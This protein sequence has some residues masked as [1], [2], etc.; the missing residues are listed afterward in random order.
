MLV[1]YDAAFWQNGEKL[2]RNPAE[3]KLLKERLDKL[4][5]LVN[6]QD[7]LRRKRELIK[8]SYIWD[9][10]GNFSSITGTRRR[11]L[12]QGSKSMVGIKNIQM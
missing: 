11:N 2:G 8:P 7:R 9:F 1:N 3:A 10:Y 4:D 6:E 5:G 12:N